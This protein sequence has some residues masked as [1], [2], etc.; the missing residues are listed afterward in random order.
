MLVLNLL[1]DA[2]IKMF[3]FQ[4]GFKEFLRFYGKYGVFLVEPTAHLY[5]V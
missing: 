3:C 1:Y 4:N 5:L 2:V